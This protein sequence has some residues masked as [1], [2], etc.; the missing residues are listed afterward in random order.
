MIQDFIFVKWKQIHHGLRKVFLE[1]SCIVARDG[2]QNVYILYDVGTYTFPHIRIVVSKRVCQFNTLMADSYPS[3][4]FQP[5]VRYIRILD[6]SRQGAFSV[7]YLL[8]LIQCW[9]LS[10]TFSISVSVYFL[11]PLIKHPFHSYSTKPH[12]Y[13]HI[14]LQSSLSYIL[15]PHNNSIHVHY[16]ETRLTFQF[17]K[18]Y[19]FRLFL[20]F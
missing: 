5:L 18:L 7:T 16:L 20:E 11:I 15:Y 12:V 14:S 2:I 4:P 10:L 3:Y 19:C 17:I 8:C 6:N 1:L 13:L 9:S